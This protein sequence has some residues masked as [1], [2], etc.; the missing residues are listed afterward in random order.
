MRRLKEVFGSR[1]GPIIF[2]PTHRSY[3]DFLIVSTVLYYY[4]M[5]VPL[6]CAGEDFLGMPFVA[7][8]LRGSGAFFMRRTF[9][10]DDLYKAIF[11]EYVNYLCKDRQ[12][13]EFFV[14]GTRSRTNKILSPKYGF[15]SVC[16]KSFFQKQVEEI[17]L[18][19]VTLNYSK[20][21]EGDTFPNELRGASKVRESTA[22]VVR[23]VS[24]LSSNFGTMMV[25]FCKPIQIS[26]FTAQKMKE[27]PDFDPFT[28][29]QDQQK[30][31][32]DL[33]NEIVHT[34]QRNIRI[35][36]TTIVASLILLYRNGISKA[37]LATK[38]QWLTLVINARGARFGSVAGLPGSNTMTQGL[39][40]L[41]NY[42]TIKGDMIE[43]RVAAEADIGNYIMLY[44]YRNPVTQLFFNESVVLGAMHSFDIGLQWKEGVSREQLFER[45]CFLSDLL[46]HEEY[47]Q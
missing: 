1:K 21:L 4:G 25:D 6:I 19:P 17:T 10:G 28:K 20:T 12:V 34:L 33:A 26:E 42:L 27:N 43:P 36:P 2:C 16:S 39:E 38:T 8:V 3:I 47:L 5:E 18:V 15:L 44:Y 22:R 37:E 23:G 32:F 9:R 11:Y 31:N 30:L 41:G 46:Q 29:K 24:V 13:M 40:H 14:E 35:M 45:A 7:D